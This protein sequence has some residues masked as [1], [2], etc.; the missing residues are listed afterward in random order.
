M[1][2]AQQLKIC[3]I[4]KKQKCARKMFSY[5]ILQY[6]YRNLQFIVFLTLSKL[7]NT[8]NRAV[9]SGVARVWAARGG[10]SVW[11]PRSP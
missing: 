1:H 7:N 2:D 8:S 10:L 6:I 3:S 5:H 9:T 4:F 11:R